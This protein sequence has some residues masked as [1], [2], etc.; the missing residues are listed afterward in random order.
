MCLG[1]SSSPRPPSNSFSALIFF[2]NFKKVNSAL[3]MGSTCSPRRL[4]LQRL[5]LQL[6]LHFHLLVQLHLQLELPLRLPLRF[7]VRHRQR[8]PAASQCVFCLF[9]ACGRG[10]DG[11]GLCH[12]SAQQVPERVG[13]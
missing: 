1:F 12:N 9:S 13:H 6:Q 2:N 8:T 11:V 4:G 3:E 5:Q 7:K 10:R